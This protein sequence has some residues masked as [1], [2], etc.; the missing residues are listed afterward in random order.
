MRIYRSQVTPNRPLSVNEAYSFSRKDCE[1][2]YP[3][4]EIPSCLFE[5]EFFDDDG[6][7][8]CRYRVSGSWVLVDGRTA[9]EFSSSFADEGEISILSSFEED[10]DGYLFPGTFFASEELAHKIVKTLVPLSPKEEGS[11]LPESGEGYAFLSEEE[12]SSSQTESPF[13]AIPDDYA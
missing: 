12:A 7:L 1:K 8:S 10:G 2:E 5:A 11:K 6:F 3:L 9:K 13:D 4:V